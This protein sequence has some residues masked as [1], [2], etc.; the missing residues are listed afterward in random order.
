MGEPLRELAIVCEKDQPFGLRVETADAEEPVKFL[1]Q[2]IENRVASMHIF[3]GGNETGRFM[4][5]NRQRWIGVNKF[6]VHFHVI[7][8][9]GL[10]AEVRADL[11]VDGDAP[12]RDQ[13][14]TIASR[15]NTGSGEETVKAHVIFE[16][17]NADVIPSEVEEFRCQIVGKT[18]GSFN[19]TQDDTMLSLLT[20]RASSLGDR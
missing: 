5:Y 13:S 4:Q 1:W 15:T 19:F 18:T 16:R 6:A 7:V 10:R 2:K 14:I 8:R 9:S 20:R 12:R 17:L 3:S 11:A